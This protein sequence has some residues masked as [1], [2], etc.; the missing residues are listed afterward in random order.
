MPDQPVSFDRW[1]EERGT[2]WTSVYG[3]ELLVK[4]SFTLEQPHDIELSLIQ[5]ARLILFKPK[6]VLASSDFFASIPAFDA[7][8]MKLLMVNLGETT[9]IAAV[10]DYSRLSHF[11]HVA[12]FDHGSIV[13][14]GGFEELHQNEA[15]LMNR[16]A[17]RIPENEDPH[18]RV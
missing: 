14:Q 8:I 6:L 16:L 17:T 3:E 2:D 4:H 5:I 1:V 10:E 18:R 13:E 7:R 9:F 15:S 12:V 11:S